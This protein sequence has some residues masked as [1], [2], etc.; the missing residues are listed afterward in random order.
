MR[1]GEPRFVRRRNQNG[2]LLVKNLA[3]VGYLTWDSKDSELPIIRQL[4]IL[5]EERGSHLGLRLIEFFASRTATRP[6]AEGIGF[7]VETPS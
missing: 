1:G 5:P 4:Y 3:Y 6:N 2:L 7:G